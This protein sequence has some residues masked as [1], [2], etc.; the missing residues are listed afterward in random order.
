MKKSAAAFAVIFVMLSVMMPPSYFLDANSNLETVLSQRMSIRNWDSAAVADEVVR[1]VC[2]NALVSAFELNGM[3]LYMLNSSGIYQYDKA[4]ITLSLK[5][6][7]DMRDELAS[8]VS[9]DFVA[10]APCIVVVVWNDKIESDSLF[11]FRKAGIIAQNLY[12]LAIRNGLG[13]VSVGDAIYLS[14]K[15][16]RIQNHL[17]LP[18]NLRPALLFP[19]GYLQT[20]QSYSSGPFQPTSGNLPNPIESDVDVL[21]LYEKSVIWGENLHV[22]QLQ[23]SNILWSTYGYSLLGT[24]HRTVPSAYDEYPFLIF[25]CNVSGV[26]SYSVESHSLYQTASGDRRSD[27]ISHANARQYME[28]APVLLLFCWNSLAGVNNAS[29]SDS[30]GAF[31]SVEIGCCIQNLY[32]SATLWNVSITPLVGTSSY[33]PLRGD[34]SS[35]S[36]PDTVYPMYLIGLGLKSILG[37]INGDYK[38]NILD[39][40]LI[41]KA[42]HA[43]PGDMRWNP[44]VDLNED[45][46][47]NIID[48]TIA[49]IYFGKEI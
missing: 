22:S 3:E 18:S 25:V 17:G 27:L 24:N 30:G 39:I 12:I 46:Q 9:Q 34:V 15:T 41:A 32:L 42:F 19:I 23:L 7:Q 14:D 26:Y 13:G 40:V 33:G 5:S 49:A 6:S 8:D 29:D 44:N 35:P 2:R 28:E 36:V 11:A 38:V 10:N 1:A 47:I 16:I 21:E 31:I 48:I 20:G 45:R 43:Q 37:D 4:S